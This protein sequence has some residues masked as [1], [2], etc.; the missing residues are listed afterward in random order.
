MLVVSPPIEAKSLISKVG[1]LKLA[2]I[3]SFSNIILII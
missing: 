2:N 1:L 3:Q